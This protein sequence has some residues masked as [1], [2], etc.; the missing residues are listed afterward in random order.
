MNN[1]SNKQN[2]SKQNDDLQNNN[3]QEIDLDQEID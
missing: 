3:N 1:E 2:Q